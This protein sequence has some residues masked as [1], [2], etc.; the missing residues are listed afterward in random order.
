MD[1]GP[2]LNVFAGQELSIHQLRL[3]HRFGDCRLSR[4][5]QEI[6]NLIIDHA[7]SM[8]ME[9]AQARWRADYECF[10]G[11]CDIAKH[12]T[13]FDPV[14]D[15]IW[16]EIFE[17]D[18]HDEGRALDRYDFT[19]YER[20]EMVQKECEEQYEN[21]SDFDFDLLEPIFENHRIAEID[22][23]EQ[24]CRCER[25][26]TAAYPDG[27]FTELNNVGVTPFNS[28]HAN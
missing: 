17:E 10:R 6:L 3:C 7:H 11:R 28:M 24:C 14:T 23:V 12:I 2:S 25:P 5:P 27:N 18:Y 4:L 26:D 9:K 15:D 13:A 19:P 8:A 22:W 21:A 20:A 16:N 1:L